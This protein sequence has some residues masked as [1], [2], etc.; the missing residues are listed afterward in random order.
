M[1]DY[2]VSCEI[3]FTQDNKQAWIHQPHLMRKIENKFGWMVKKLQT[4]K[5]L[6]TP[7]AYIL[8]NPGTTISEKEQK[9]YRS[10]VGM[11][12]YLVKLS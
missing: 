12:L 4:Y 3:S 6:G 11:L 1:Y 8:Q 9:I 2:L 7:E 5:T 10:G